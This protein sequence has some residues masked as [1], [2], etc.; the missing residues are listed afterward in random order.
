M[1]QIET[2][3]KEKAALR[4]YEVSSSDRLELGMKTSG[5][6]IYLSRLRTELA[7]ARKCNFVSADDIARV[8]NGKGFKTGYGKVW[9]ARLVK[10][11]KTVVAD[12]AIEQ[13]TTRK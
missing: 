7:L 1:R 11:A 10:I 13:I 4:R 9:T 8:W 5:W 3:E 6:T 2:M 12:A